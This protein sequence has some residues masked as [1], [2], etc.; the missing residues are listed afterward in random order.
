MVMTLVWNNAKT[1][2]QHVEYMRMFH[3]CGQTDTGVGIALLESMPAL[4]V[5]PPM[6]ETGGS[7]DFIN[8]NDEPSLIIMQEVV[9]NSN[10]QN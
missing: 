6:R 9:L 10:S 2:K 3:M 1:F 8:M 5:T 7:R 4:H